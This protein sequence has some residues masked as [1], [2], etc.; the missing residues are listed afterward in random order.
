MIPGGPGPEPEG[1]PGGGSRAAPGGGADFPAVPGRGGRSASPSHGLRVRQSV[2][3]RPR[4]RVKPQAEFFA[5]V[6]G[7]TPGRPVPPGLG[8]CRPRRPRRP[9]AYGARLDLR[10]RNSLGHGHG[11]H[12]YS[13]STQAE[14]QSPRSRAEAAAAGGLAGPGTGPGQLTRNEKSTDAE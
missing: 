7:Q 1:R 11:R 6:S 13:L 12:L 3:H 8:P 10:D 2:A 5:R 14:F 4:G 9:P